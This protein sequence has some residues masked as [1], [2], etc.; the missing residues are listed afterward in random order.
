M[1]R[2]LSSRASSVPV[3]EVAPDGQPALVE[4]DG[5]V[6]LAQQLQQHPE[7]VRDPGQR[8]S[9][10]IGGQRDR[11]LQPPAPFGG[12]TVLVPERG[13]RLDQPQA[14]GY[15]LVVA[16]WACGL[17]F[18]RPAQRGAQVVLFGLQV[19]QGC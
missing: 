13:Q 9:G 6:E 14:G 18:Q 17:G 10:I 15:A 19:V 7:P 4:R 16:G 5:R 12:V 3:A 2:L 11:L 8:C 1:P